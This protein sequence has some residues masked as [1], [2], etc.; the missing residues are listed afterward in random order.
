MMSNRNLDRL[1]TEVNHELTLVANNGWLRV[2]CHLMLP[3]TKTNFIIFCSTRKRHFE[4]QAKLKLN[5]TLMEQ[6]YFATFFGFYID[7]QTSNLG[8]THSKS[9]F[10]IIT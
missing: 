6:V 9:R 4:T 10:Q 7:K 2:N 5:G 3:Y 1:I 8:Q